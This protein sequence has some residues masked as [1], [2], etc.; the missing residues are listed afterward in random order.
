MTAV[1]ETI[2]LEPTVAR[3]A[4]ELFAVQRQEIYR[5]T[6]RLFALLMVVQWVAGVVAALVIA[7]RAWSGTVSQPHVHVYA[8]VYLGG[9]IAS[10]PVALAFV[11]PGAPITR[12]VIA[13]AQILFSSLLIHLT[14]GRIE[15]HFHVFGSL[16]FLAFYRD[17]R[18]LLTASLVVGVDHFVRGVLWP[19]SVYGVVGAVQWRFLEHVGW[20]AFE[21]IFLLVATRQSLAQMRAVAERQAMLESAK[22]AV[23][24]ANRAKS[25]F[26]AHM[27]H[28]IRT[29]M[30]AILGYADLIA[31]DGH[32]PHERREF[33]QTI[34]RNGEHL[35]S[36]LNDILDISKIE[37][38]RLAVER[39]KCSPAQIVAE[40]VSTMRPRA[41]D[42]NLQLK[43][44]FET[45]IPETIETDPTRLRQILL[46]LLSNAIKFTHAGEVVISLRLNGDENGAEPQLAM[47]VRDTGIGMTAEHCQRLFEPFTQADGSTSRRYGGTGLGLS[48]SKRLAERLGGR[49]EVESEVGRGSAFTVTLATGALD[50][51][52]MVTIHH[53]S[54]V[55]G[56]ARAAAERA[57]VRDLTGRL[58]LVD[59][60]NDNRQ[61]LARLLKRVG[62]DVETAENGAL[63][64]ERILPATN[65]DAF[66]LVL[67]DMQ[68]PEMDGYEATARLR[69]SGY[70][71]RIMALTAHASDA[72]REKCLA[73]GCD[74]Y[75]AKP[76]SLDQLMGAIRRQIANGDF[77]HT[78]TASPPTK[79]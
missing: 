61:L 32:A 67:M 34:H 77:A 56:G 46:N 72:D 38:G 66:D 69:R 30:T 47:T 36:V 28:E 52:Q 21:D 76:Y 10:F 12:H 2:P 39:V 23:E 64:V 54:I 6:D 71:G 55:R 8:A 73:A 11:M 40:A 41:L 29:P 74:D 31:A 35:L 19:Q 33:L 20:V 26:L 17:W 1:A 48:I 45:P 18:V 62:L 16:A 70:T 44:R 63:A 15:T 7:P 25:A 13:V 65:G 5:H 9:L 51:V 3:R 68:M 59:D 58:L 75:L 50:G 60:S 57:D 49:I 24:S 27:S 53:E 43:T 78:D 37:A 14:G 4:D 22:L 42:K 79:T